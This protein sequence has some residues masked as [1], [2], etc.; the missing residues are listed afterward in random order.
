[1]ITLLIAIYLAFNGHPWIALLL[2][3]FCKD[4]D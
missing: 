3:F 2:V 1:M 4:D